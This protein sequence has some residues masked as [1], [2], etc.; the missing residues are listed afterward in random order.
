MDI[1]LKKIIL[2]ANS[3][4]ITN[5]NSL[6][7]DQDIVVRFNFPNKQKIENTGCRTDILFLANTVDLMEDRLKNKEF[8]EFI[9]SLKETIIF[10]PYDDDLISKINPK[11]K[12]VHRK[13]FIKFKKYI[14]NSNNNKYI[15]Y[16]LE[17]NIKVKVIDQSYYWN[18]KKIANIDDL[19]ILS[20]GLIA[21]SYFLNSKSYID[22][23]I[24]LCGF[25]FE[26]WGRHSWDKEKKYILDLKNNNKI[27]FI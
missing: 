3:D 10:F 14:E 4:H 26:G 21:T 5:I 23:K 7:N 27:Y 17:K 1:K 6:I 25:T 11:C 2:V 24:Y 19:S 12:V 8:S 16:F 9:N 18:A 20:T 15:N 13:F 22:Y